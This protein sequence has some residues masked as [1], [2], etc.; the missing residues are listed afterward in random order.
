L[1][2]FPE[3]AKRG[4][5]AVK[6]Y[7]AQ[8]RPME[9]RFAVGVLVVL[10]LVLNW[11][12]IWPHFSDWG[13]LQR[14]GDDARRKLKLYQTAIAQTPAYEKQVNT[15]QS[16]GEFVAPEDLAINMMRTIQSQA[17]Q[18]GVGIVNYS[19][20][21]VHTNQFFMEQMQNISAIAD[22]KQLV[23]FLYKL[24]SGS[25]MTRVIDL[26]LQPDAA[27]QHLNANI[28]LVASYQKNATASNLKPAT[29]KA[30]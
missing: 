20:S 3:T 26:E 1:E 15:L 29:A 6:K 2:F 24:G 17:A 12:F 30:K 23:D 4:G 8:L 27:K 14:R 10:F 13:N 19:R 22:D 5:D 25:S 18:S 11:V 9:R 16:Q 21:I 7:L 28:R